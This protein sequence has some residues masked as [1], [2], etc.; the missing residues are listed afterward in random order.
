MNA[1][2][3]DPSPSCA[4]EAEEFGRL[5]VE[6]ALAAMLAAVEPVAGVERV[7]LDE[8]SDRVL[9]EAA[10]APF[11][12][13]PC[14]NS[15]V[16]GY[17]IRGIELP[18]PG[19]RAEF[20]VVGTILAGQQPKPL[21]EGCAMAIMTG[22]PL[23]EGADTVLM[24]EQVRVFGDRVSCDARHRAGDNVRRAGEDMRAGEIV[25]RAG[26]RLRPADLGVLASLGV[27]EVAVR[28]RL[29]LALLSTGDELRNLGDTRDPGCIYD[30]NRHALGA[31][32]RR[33]GIDVVDLGLVADE[34]AALRATLLAAAAQADGI[35]ASGGV[36]AGEA[37]YVKPV[38]AEIGEIAFWKVAIKPGR[39]IAFGR[40][41]RAAFFGLPGNPVAALVTFYALIRPVLARLAG[42]SD[43]DPPLLLT[44]RCEEHLR[45]KP[46]RTEYPRGVLFRDAAG[47]WRVRTT[48]KQGSGILR[49]MS[50]ANAFIV[51]PHDRGPVEPGE[52]V[53]V[54]PFAGLV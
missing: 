51:L 33:L 13:P 16:D 12:V 26:R 18:E 29:R 6:E 2:P 20:P 17:A 35:V 3:T 24:R 37:D 50:L 7:A 15:A 5:R 19:S 46:G 32:L 48:G 41:G 1:L 38:L 21:P 43:V 40:I 9:A 54:M 25:L 39:P 10:V 52:T 8:A 14:A 4:D 44:A 31:A 45:K 53:T 34:P 28:R 11:D 49:S 23:P 30:S 47:E 22:A 27:G 36:S 42:C